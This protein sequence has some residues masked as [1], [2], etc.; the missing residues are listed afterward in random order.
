MPLAS[1]AVRLSPD[2]SADSLAGRIDAVWNRSPNAFV[3]QPRRAFCCGGDTAG[4]GYGVDL[5]T[6]SA[7]H[8]GGNLRRSA[9]RVDD[10]AVLSA[11]A[12][13]G[14]SLRHV[15]ASAPLG[16]WRRWRRALLAMGCKEVA[17]SDSDHHLVV[18]SGVLGGLVPRGVAA[19][20]GDVCGI[21]GGLGRF[22]ALAVLSSSRGAWAGYGLPVSWIEYAAKPVRGDS[23]LSAAVVLALPAGVGLRLAGGPEPW[24]RF[25]RERW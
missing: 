10:G 22:A 20:V 15:A 12:L 9:L 17:V 18:R 3:A 16:G 7:A 13:R 14:H 4:V 2:E 25:C 1:Q 21:G 19:A 24:A 8:R 6:A 23:A 5:D 11:G